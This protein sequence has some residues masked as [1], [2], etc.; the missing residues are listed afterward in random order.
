MVIKDYQ[1][2]KLVNEVFLCIQLNHLG[3]PGFP[4]QIGPLGAKGYPG[5]I[6]LP[7]RPGRI[8]V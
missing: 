6:G 7:G 4:G 2:V 1:V 3:T 5:Q 8:Y